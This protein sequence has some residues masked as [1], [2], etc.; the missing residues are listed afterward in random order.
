MQIQLSFFDALADMLCLSP[1]FLAGFLISGLLVMRT[2]RKGTALSGFRLL[3]GSFVFY[4]YLCILLKHVVGIPT[5]SELERMYQHSHSFFHPILNLIPFGDGISISL[6]LNIVLFLPMGFLCPVISIKCQKPAI[7]LLMGTALTA[8]VEISQMFTMYRATDI[9]DLIA[10]ILGTLAGYLMY[11]V[12]FRNDRVRF[13]A[14][15]P[16]TGKDWLLPMGLAGCG[17]V[18]TFFS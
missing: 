3:A 11:R 10:N 8:F 16:H 2:V 12:V 7:T 1:I 4:Y 9:D 18:M 5:L 6:L 15:I 14:E 17:V 13:E